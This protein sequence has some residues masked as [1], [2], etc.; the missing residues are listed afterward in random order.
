MDSWARRS[1]VR[2][3]KQGKRWHLFLLLFFLP[4]LTKSYGFSFLQGVREI[5]GG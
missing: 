5:F 1:R 4:E 2:E 3:A